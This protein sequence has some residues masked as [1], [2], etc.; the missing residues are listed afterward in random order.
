MTLMWL[1]RLVEAMRPASFIWD[2]RWC[3]YSKKPVVDLEL[4]SNRCQV[5]RPLGTVGIMKRR[6]YWYYKR[7]AVP[8]K[9]YFFFRPFTFYFFLFLILALNLLLLYASWWVVELTY[10]AEMEIL[11]SKKLAHPIDICSHL[12]RFYSHYCRCFALLGDDF[13]ENEAL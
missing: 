1:K 6:F 2:P 10:D 7:I 3:S 12:Q 5:G 4:K 13:E 8:F 9:N 11:V